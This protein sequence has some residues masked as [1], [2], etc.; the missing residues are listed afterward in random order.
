MKIALTADAHLTTRAKNPERYNA[1]ENIFEQSVA[2]NV[3]HF[4]I[5]GDLFDQETGN[6]SEFESLCGAYSNLQFHIIPGNHDPGISSKNVTG[7][8][9]HI[10]T[11]PTFQEI[12]FT[13][14]LL[15]PYEEEKS[16][17]EAIAPIRHMIGGEP[18]ILVGHGDFYGGVTHPNPLE[19]GT[20]M[21]L[22]R[23][24]LE[25]LEPRTV[26]LGHIHV[27]HDPVSNVH[28]VGSP[29]GLDIT[30][31][32]RRSFL[33]Y[34]TSNGTSERVGVETDVLYFQ[35][36]FFVIPSEGELETLKRQVTAR[37]DGWD[38]EVADYPKV[39][40]RVGVRGYTKD[41]TALLQTLEEG[42]S[43]FSYYEDQGPNMAD[44]SF[45]DDDQLE[46]IANR[47]LELIDELDWAWGDGGEP[48]QEQA[49]LAALSVIY[50][51]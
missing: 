50:Q 7:Q 34:D 32:G 1:L 48:E 47:T 9:I 12:D 2:R 18:W 22:S 49:K 51:D 42:F 21:P 10:Y 39:Q 44:L 37:I 25:R 33:C 8:N 20:Y 46:V 13:R 31:T 16:M 40:V 29:S 28:Y 6:Y 41:R 45:S 19:P 27:P 24:D 11:R 30:E 23:S 26:F 3:E 38:I 43:D 4:I 15:V 14:F 17:G 36:T 5:A 35:E